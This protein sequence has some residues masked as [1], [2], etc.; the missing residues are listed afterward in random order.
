MSTKKKKS[1]D[2]KAEESK[3]LMSEIKKMEAEKR[4]KAMRAQEKSKDK[5]KDDK[6]TYDTW[7]MMRSKKIPQLHRKEIIRFKG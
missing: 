2:K 7:W 6:V 1:T 4:D 3:D 5:K